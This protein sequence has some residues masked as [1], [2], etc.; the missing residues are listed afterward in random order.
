[1][2][3]QEIYL[4]IF[5]EEIKLSCSSD[6]EESDK[7]KESNVDVESDSDDGSEIRGMLLSNDISGAK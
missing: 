2:S 7:A 6:E 1:M 4:G 3:S 5:D